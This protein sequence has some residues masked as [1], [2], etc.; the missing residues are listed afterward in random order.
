MITIN[1]FLFFISVLLF[2]TGVVAQDSAPLAPPSSAPIPVEVFFG[3]NRFVSQFTMNK[4]FTGSERFGLIAN[5]YIAASYDNDKTKNESMNFLYLNYKIY[6]G[7]GLV[8]GAALNSH[9][10]FRPFSGAM[11]SYANKTFFAMLLSGFYLT[12]SHNF[13]SKVIIQYKP[14]IKGKWSIYSRLEALYN[15]DMDTN[16]H[17]RSY[18]YGRFGL[19]HKNIGFGLATNYD[20]YGPFKAS[21]ENFGIFILYAFK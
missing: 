2:S 6:K 14:H 11:Y 21:R 3:N 5:S 8:G 1:K 7:F 15:Q 9:W 12:E 19:N 18:L 17:D 20:R 13:E 10:G 4:K 16:K